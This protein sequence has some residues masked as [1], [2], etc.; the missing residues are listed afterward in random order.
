MQIDGIIVLVENIVQMSNNT[1]HDNRST[2]GTPGW[3]IE[4]IGRF[5]IILCLSSAAAAEIM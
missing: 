3:F 5:Q 1:I 2:E 4:W